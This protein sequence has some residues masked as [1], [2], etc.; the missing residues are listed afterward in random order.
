MIVNERTYFLF[1]FSG[2]LLYELIEPCDKRLER[3]NNFLKDLSPQ[4]NARVIPIDNPFGPTIVE[5]D[6]QLLVVSHE[7]IRGGQKINELRQQKGFPPLQVHSIQLYEESKKESEHEEDKISS[8][9]QRIRNLGDR[10]RPPVRN[11]YSV[12]PSPP[13]SK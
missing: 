2:K 5:K 11:T 12:I 9:S 1:R 8:S 6:I 7:T 3:V 13:V 10:L 4:I